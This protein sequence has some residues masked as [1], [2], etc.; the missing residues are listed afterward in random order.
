MHADD[1][2]T[3]TLIDE[4]LP[5]LQRL[6]DQRC[7]GRALFMLGDRARQHG[8]RAAATELLRLRIQAAEPA[9]DRDTLHSARNMLAD[10]VA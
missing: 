4:C 5:V 1:A 8:D 10:L 3:K 2:R 7:T 9:A 6:G